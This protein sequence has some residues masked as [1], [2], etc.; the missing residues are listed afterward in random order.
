[1]KEVAPVKWKKGDLLVV[2]GILL[3]AFGLMAFR[4][5]PASSGNRLLR[6]ELEG[7]LLEEILFNEADFEQFP[8]EFPA[9]TAT[10]EI[11]G[12]RVR[13]LPMPKEVCPL[14]ICS[15]IGWVEQAGDAIVCLPNRLVLT[16]LGGEVNELWDSLD[17]V[18]R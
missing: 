13:V 6:V 4:S 9:G 7:V 1:M 11:A 5:L 10:V 18:T 15:S 17:G 16:V 2:A 3:V 14:G 12:G 8:I